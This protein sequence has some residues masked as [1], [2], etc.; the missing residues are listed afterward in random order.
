M[1]DRAGLAVALILVSSP[2]VAAHLNTQTGVGDRAEVGLDF[3]FTQ[4]A[5]P[6]IVSVTSTGALPSAYSIPMTT[7]PIP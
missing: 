6:S 3:G 5:R 2:C 1:V 4:D 7:R